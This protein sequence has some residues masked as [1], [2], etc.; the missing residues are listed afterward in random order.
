MSVQC[1]LG[2]KSRIAEMMLIDARQAQRIRGRQPCLPFAAI[3]AMQKDVTRQVTGGADRA[4]VDQRRADDRKQ[5]DIGPLL[6][7]ALPPV[8]V[9]VVKADV[10]I[11]RAQVAPVVGAEQPEPDVRILRHEAAES[12]D[13]PQRQDRGH[14]ANCKLAGRRG[15]RHAGGRRRDPIE[16]GGDR[17]KQFGAVG[18]E[19]EP[20]A[21]ALEQL[22]LEHELQR[23]DLVADGAVRDVEFS[24]REGQRP[25]A[26]GGLEGAQGIER[27]QALAHGDPRMIGQ[28]F[29]HITVYHCQLIPR[30][31][32]GINAAWGGVS[33]D[34]PRVRTKPAPNVRRLGGSQ[35]AGPSR[36]ISGGL[37]SSW[38]RQVAPQQYAS[39]RATCGVC[40]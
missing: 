13:Q 3:I 26:R 7:P 37:P 22:D 12:R 36:S 39:C 30:L 14:A 27:R 16:R 17:G 28:Y 29:S 21:H 38:S 2:G 9:A 35:A 33:E 8:A 6:E 25:M 32:R 19:L 23:P 5:Q 31:R 1:R 15:A 10:D 11:G 34:C 18:R 20:P 24:R 40:A 4:L